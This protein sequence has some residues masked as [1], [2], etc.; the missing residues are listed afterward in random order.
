MWPFWDCA[1]LCRDYWFLGLFQQLNGTLTPE[2]AL[3][4]RRAWVGLAVAA[5]ITAAA[6]A[7]CYVHT[8]R[9]LVEEPGNFI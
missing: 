3:L 9:K 4:A 1:Y 5:V 2:T 8:L 6:Y 7:I